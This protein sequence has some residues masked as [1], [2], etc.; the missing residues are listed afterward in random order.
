M[1][2]ETKKRIEDVEW[3]TRDLQEIIMNYIKK[4]DELVE[5]TIQIGSKEDL[6]IGRVERIE[7]IFRGEPRSKMRNKYYEHNKEI[8]ITKVLKEIIETHPRISTEEICD[9]AMKKLRGSIHYIGRNKIIAF[10][11]VLKESKYVKVVRKEGTRNCN[12]YEWT[13]SKEAFEEKLKSY[14]DM[15]KTYSEK[16][17]F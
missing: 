10:L 15:H 8:H 12:I 14:E 7:S 3:F 2:E 1:D 17:G 16:M 9:L 4:H 13:M 11:K 5:N 6:L